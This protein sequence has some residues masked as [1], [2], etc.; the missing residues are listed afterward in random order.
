LKILF[1]SNLFAPDV[2]GGASL[3]SDLSLFLSKRSCEVRIVTTFPYYPSWSITPQDAIQPYRIELWNNIIL[4][5]V[6]MFVPRRPSG[7]GR[8]LSDISFLAALLRD[9]R[10]DGWIPDVVLTASPMFSQ[11]LAQRFLYFGLQIP[12]M[13]VVQ[14]FVVD[15]A[16]ELGILRLPG[17]R[18]MLRAL[19]R[20]SF[21]SAKTLTTISKP[22]LDKLKSIVGKD[23]RLVLIPNWIHRSLQ[24]EIDVQRPTAPPRKETVLFYSGNLGIKQGLPSF[25]KDFAQA[26][27]GWTLKIHGGG[28]QLEAV[29][30]AVTNTPGVMA[31]GVLSE[32]AYVTE[33]FHCTACLVTQSPG[34]GANFLPSKLLPALATGTPVLAVCE[35]D[36]PLGQEVTMGGFGA[37]IHPKDPEAL[38]NVLHSWKKNP[39]ILSAMGEKA[40]IWSKRYHRDK[41]LPL[42]FKELSLLSPHLR[43]TEAI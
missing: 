27:A 21:R 23:R 33:L 11:C 28:A 10:H 42:Y 9:G 34:V 30:S 17:L 3:F 38:R 29:E 26:N 6:R 36:S 37:V 43:K 32:S 16:L 20:W 14:D 13:I 31:G 24:T 40:L 7:L 15:A 18:L 2:L 25:L 35:S 5:R 19:E 22:M 1:Y 39:Q 41:I 12:R 8:L 4:K